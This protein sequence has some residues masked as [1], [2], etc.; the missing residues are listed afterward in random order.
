M[1]KKSENNSYDALS[2]ALRSP[3]ENPENS[4]ASD[5]CANSCSILEQTG[6]DATI[7]GLNYRVSRFFRKIDVGDRRLYAHIARVQ[8]DSQTVHL[9]KIVLTEQKGQTDLTSPNLNLLRFN[10]IDGDTALHVYDGTLEPLINDP[11]YLDMV[12]DVI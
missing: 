12:S 1:A 4:R 7:N 2:A 8:A 3:G 6:Y 11:V 10:E 9:P 5:L